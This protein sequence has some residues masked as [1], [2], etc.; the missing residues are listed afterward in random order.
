M[1]YW[2]K[3]SLRDREKLFEF[4]YLHHPVV[5]NKTDDLIVAKVTALESH[6]NM[7]VQRDDMPGRLLILPDISMVVVYVVVP[8]TRTTQQN[9]NSTQDIKILRVLHQKRPFPLTD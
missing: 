4:L 1:I 5:A 3:E 7:G 2:E 6:P 8:H 9:T